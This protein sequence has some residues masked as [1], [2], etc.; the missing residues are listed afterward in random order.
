MASKQPRVQSSYNAK[1]NFS[2]DKTPSD[3]RSVTE[4]SINE[5]KAYCSQT[6]SRKY[7]GSYDAR[8]LYAMVG[9]II[10][11]FD[12]LSSKLK[13]DYSSRKN[14][15]KNAQNQ[16]VKK[17]NQRIYEFKNLVSSHESALKRFSN[18][19]S[20]YDGEGAEEMLHYPL[21][22]IKEFENRIKT[23]EEKNNEA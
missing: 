13:E 10:G 23:I 15:M 5:I 3:F 22:R 11:N 16:G 17:V 9:T 21:E 2:F 19:L 4:K 18:N 1:E 8:T 14:K 7:K 12:L 6:L 20:D